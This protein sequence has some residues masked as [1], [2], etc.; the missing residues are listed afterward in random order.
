MAGSLIDCAYTSDDGRR[1]LI[2]IDKSN[3]L[4]GG[5][6]PILQADLSLDY[7][8]RNLEPRYVTCKHPTRSVRR[9]I[10]IP[11]LTS[12][13]WSG[14]ITSITLTDYQDNSQQ[15]FSVK[16]RNSQRAKY[17]PNLIDTYQTDNP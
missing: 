1:W 2:R 4:A 3:A 15:S 14:A 13:L 12:G 7:L 16:S 9:D 11:S 10:Y 17:L 5:F 6:T 8:P